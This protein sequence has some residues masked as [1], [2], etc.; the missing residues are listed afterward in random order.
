MSK[1]SKPP[2]FRLW[3]S[4]LLCG[5]LQGFMAC[6]SGGSSGSGTHEA[7]V[8]ASKA[9]LGEN[10]FFDVNLSNDRTQSCATCHNPEHAFIDNRLD[11]NGD[12]A[13]VSMGDD[14]VSLGDRNTPSAAYAQFSPQFGLGG[15]ARFNSKQP[16]Y[17]GYVG[18]QFL[19][20]RENDLIGQAGGPPLN[21]LEM[22]LPDKETAVARLQENA[23]YQKGFKQLFGETV[24]ADVDSAYSAM[25]ESLA[26]FEQTEEFAPFDSKYDRSLS[27]DYIYHPASKAAQGKA[28]F[29][30]AQFTNCATCHQLLPNGRA[31]ETF[32]SYEY[33]N[34]GVPENTLVRALN[35]KAQE[36]VDFGLF[37]N[38]LIDDEAQKGKF[39]VP[40]LR[41]VAVTAP[42]MHN[43]VFKKLSTVIQFY[44]H[45]LTDSDFPLNPETGEPWADPEVQ[46]NISLD[47]LQEGRKL[48]PAKVE[49]IV[50]FLYTL[51]D[52][53]YEH[54]LPTDG[55]DCG[56]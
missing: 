37:D 30:S 5:L 25:A 22:A 56:E 7:L 26:A 53:R 12:I 50:C 31:Q 3:R 9:E 52:A 16:D 20:G 18:G 28:E 47:E 29:F 14:G 27:G 42:Y 13:A 19:E 17:V 46:E 32:T 1:N 38:P 35:G 6:S 4:L 40:T 44:D 36:F 51:T 55:P 23:L 2:V 54:L 8:F 45:Y 41:N 43:G 33:H 34:I 11:A 21:P 49:A 15:H 39:K 24:W 10:L 48:T